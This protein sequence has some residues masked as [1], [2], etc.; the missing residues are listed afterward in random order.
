MGIDINRIEDLELLLGIT[1]LRNTLDT[2]IESIWIPFWT[3]LP[4]HLRTPRTLVHNKEIVFSGLRR[5]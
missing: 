5:I 4:K 2:V 3:H 1:S